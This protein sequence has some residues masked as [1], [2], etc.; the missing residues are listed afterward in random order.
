METLGERLRKLRIQRNLSLDELAA[1]ASVSKAYLWRLETNP[2]ANPSVDVAQKLAEA[3]EVGVGT[4][5]APP[6]GVANQEVDIPPTLSQAQQSFG[7]PDQDLVDLSRI[8]FRGGQPFSAEDWGLLY[9]Q[10]KKTVS[11][12]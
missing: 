8:R 11:G 3:L 1:Q 9:L 6:A 2:D 10:L 7:I 5:I 4:L 12:D